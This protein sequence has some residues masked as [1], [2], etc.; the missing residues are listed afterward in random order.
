MG[1]LLHAVL[2]VWGMDLRVKLRLHFVGL[3]LITCTGFTISCH[4]DEWCF[5]VYSDINE[6][7]KR[8]CHANATCTNF[9]GSFVCRCNPFFTGNGYTCTGQFS[10]SDF[11]INV[12]Y[13][14]WNFVVYHIHFLCSNVITVFTVVTELCLI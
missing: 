2:A 12:F 8:P 6:C 10:S 14:K 3:A 4:N 7:S 11:I 1:A 5:F 13:V 9:P